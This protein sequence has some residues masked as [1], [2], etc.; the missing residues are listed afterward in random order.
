M[1][2]DNPVNQVKLIAIDEIHIL[3]PR[4]RNKA[5]FQNVV[6]SIAAVGLKRPIKVS[7][8]PP[9]PGNIDKKYNLV[10]GQ[11]RLEAFLQL[12]ESKIP[13]IVVDL[14]KEECYL[15]SLVENLARRNHAPIELVRDFARLAE[16][17]YTVTEIA[18]KTGLCRKY[19][20]G[21]LRLNKYGEE[22]LMA[23]VEKGE[24][25]VYIAVDIATTKNQSAQAALTRAY[26][27]NDLR[28][29]K[30]QSAIRVIRVRERRGK[31]I[32]RGGRKDKR[33]YNSRAI[34]TEYKRETE[35]Q[36]VLIRR[37]NVT[38]TRLTVLKGAL[39]ALLADENFATLL[40]AEGLD[41]MPSQVAELVE[42][43]AEAS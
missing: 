1:M 4:E 18:K 27:R 10:C 26:E 19:V 22:R 37:A 31:K 41:S 23:A 3:N 39:Q 20:L 16:H 32:V 14:S 2:A 43:Q 9:S 34:V 29:G 12:G 8:R 42:A 33:T 30:L 38:E 17:G 28:G 13:A 7:V 5:K 11:G 15:Q 36:R 25:P 35:R 6:D 40:H 24:I 21:M